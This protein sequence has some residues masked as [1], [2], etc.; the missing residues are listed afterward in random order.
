VGQNSKPAPAPPNTHTLVVGRGFSALTGVG[1]HMG[2]GI[3]GRFPHSKGGRLMTLMFGQRDI[4]V[5]YNDVETE[6]KFY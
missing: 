3:Y 5:L 1:V 6:T 4:I 2:F